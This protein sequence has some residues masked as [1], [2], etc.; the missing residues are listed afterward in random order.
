MRKVSITILSLLCL[1]VFGLGSVA[2]QTNNTNST[3]SSSSAAAKSSQCTTDTKGHQVCVVPNDPKTKKLVNY[4]C[5]RKDSKNQTVTV[6][7]P[8]CYVGGFFDPNDPEDVRCACC[9]D[10][11]VSRFLA[12]GIKIAQWILGLSGSAALVI[13]VYG[14]FLWILSG[15]DPGRIDKGKK[16]LT[17]AVIGVIIVLTAWLI[18]NF[19]LG[20]LVQNKSMR[21]AIKDGDYIGGVQSQFKA[22]QKGKR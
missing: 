16:A 15:G 20:I 3:T 12:L 5:E 14:G 19:I 18:I 2:A 8:S 9:G 4:I 17:G 6:T 10:C 1:F 21:D 11:D 7:V 13:I 22:D